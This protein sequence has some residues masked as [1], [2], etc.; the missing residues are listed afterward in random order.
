VKLFLYHLIITPQWY[1]P[2][3]DAVKKANERHEKY[4]QLLGQLEF[5]AGLCPVCIARVKLML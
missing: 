3:V 5:T 4:S 1:K 2:L